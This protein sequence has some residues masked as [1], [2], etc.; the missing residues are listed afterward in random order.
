MPRRGDSRSCS[1]NAGSGCVRRFARYSGIGSRFAVHRK[2]RW[3]RSSYYRSLRC[4]IGVLLAK[5][6]Q[7]KDKSVKRLAYCRGRRS[8]GSGA[9]EANDQE[10][11]GMV[12]RVSYNGELGREA[13]PWQKTWGR[14]KPET[15]Q[16][17]KEGIEN[18]EWMRKAMGKSFRKDIGLYVPNVSYTARRM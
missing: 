6:N 15:T 9:E 5:E 11:L 2:W 4:W 14:R 12:S 1:P 7:W 13:I 10:G 8:Q 18:I 16:G 3:S 17:D